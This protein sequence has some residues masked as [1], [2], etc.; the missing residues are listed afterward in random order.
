M[1][2]QLS[3]VHAPVRTAVAVRSGAP[4]RD[5]LRKATAILAIVFGIAIVAEP[6]AFSLWSD[7]PAGQRITERFDF[8]LSRPGLNALTTNFA[9]VGAMGD[10]FFKQTLPAVQSDLHMTDAEFADYLKTSHPA[11]AHAQVEIPAAV[12]L[13][14]PVNPQLVAVHGDFEAVKSLPGVFGLPLKSI[15]WLLV[16]LGGA[17]IAVGAAALRWPGLWTTAAIATAGVAM[18]AVALALSLPHKANAAVRVAR[19]GNVALS[20]VAAKAAID[21]TN[22]IDALVKD[23]QTSFIPDV[24]SRL[25][26]SP[27][28]FTAS[29][30]TNYPAVARGLRAWPGIR[31]G[32]YALAAAQRESLGDRPRL[33]SIPFRLFPWLVIGPGIVLALLAGTVLLQDTRRR[34]AL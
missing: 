5:S 9:T 16:G 33:D 28:A 20:P 3:E 34:I 30:E 4:R 6:F 31:P 14:G 19:V 21:T 15:P 27:T 1:S 17:L 22:T 23:V 8:T 2:T 25:G 13:V 29:V 26:T 32:A 12:A 18:V 11:I 24:S 7:A 10:Q